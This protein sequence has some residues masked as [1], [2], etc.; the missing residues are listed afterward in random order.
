MPVLEK[1]MREVEEKRAKGLLNGILA[2]NMAC[3]VSVD[4]TKKRK[5]RTAFSQAALDRLN[6]FFQ[7]KSHPT[8]D[9]MDILA[10][11]LKYD[12]ETVRVWFCNKRQSLHKTRSRNGNE[13]DNQGNDGADFSGQDSCSE[14]SMCSVDGYMVNNNTQSSQDALMPPSNPWPVTS[15]TISAPQENPAPDSLHLSNSL[16]SASSDSAAN[17]TITVNAT[18]AVEGQEPSADLIPPQIITTT[19]T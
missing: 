19:I 13:N 15:I 8:A 2:E 17:A 4:G 1:W 11:E 18:N 14:M 5:R 9:E 3:E 16:D 12:R 7:T 10:D 6:A